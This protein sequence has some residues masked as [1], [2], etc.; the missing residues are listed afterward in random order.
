MAVLTVR[1]YETAK[2]K[3]DVKA[4]KQGLNTSEFVRQLLAKELKMKPKEVFD[5]A[6]TELLEVQK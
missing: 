5:S 3:L 2:R 1:L 6:S 4:R